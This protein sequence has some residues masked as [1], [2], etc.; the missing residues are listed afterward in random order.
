MI[1]YD[2]DNEYK[3]TDV[4]GAVVC[5]DFKD[6]FVNLSKY[7]IQTSMKEKSTTHL[8]NWVIEVSEDGSNWFEIDRRK[9][10]ESLNEP[11]K[12]NVFDVQNPN[13]NFYRYLRLRQ[14]GTSHYNCENCNIFSISRFD[15]YGQIKVPQA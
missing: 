11:R 12:S 9:N 7:Q 13:N 4:G 3:S 10:D 6:K 1:D 14:I 8:K 5:F 2:K 15:F